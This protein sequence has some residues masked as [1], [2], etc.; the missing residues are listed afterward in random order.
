MDRVLP[1]TNNVLEC[2]VAALILE[3]TQSPLVGSLKRQQP[4]HAIGIVRE[5][6]MLGAIDG[7][8]KDWCEI[9]EIL[10]WASRVIK[11]FH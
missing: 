8:V 2:L 3:E 6:W 7:N 1:E 4:F 10:V 9:S 5:N 11:V